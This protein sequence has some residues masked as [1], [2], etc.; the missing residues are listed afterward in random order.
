MAR[1][2]QTVPESGDLL[3]PPVKPGA[4]AATPGRPPAVVPSILEYT[5][6]NS[7]EKWRVEK[8]ELLVAEFE[9]VAAEAAD[10]PGQVAHFHAVVE[11]YSRQWLIV[12]R[13]FGFSPVLLPD[14]AQAS[15]Y[16]PLNHKALGDLLGIE[17]AQL[18]A[19]LNAIRVVWRQHV[20]PG[21]EMA[22][23]PVATPANALNF[24]DE[25]LREFAF[26]EA[27]RIDTMRADCSLAML[28]RTAW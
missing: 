17:P 19:E 14:D 4:T 15:D 3:A 21:A 5:P 10:W 1:R 20:L 6:L 16:E 25:V 27:L 26:S 22:S 11:Q 28:S 2:K 7:M 9:L 13:L 23:E 24:G 18:Q 8:F 12:R